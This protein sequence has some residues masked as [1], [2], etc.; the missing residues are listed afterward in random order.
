MQNQEKILYQAVLLLH[1]NGEKER[2]KERKKE[3]KKEMK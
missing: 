3:R 1:T 2:N